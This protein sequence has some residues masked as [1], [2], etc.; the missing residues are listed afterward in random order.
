MYTTAAFFI[1][2]RWKEEEGLLY[3][4]KEKISST[5]VKVL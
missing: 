3:G 1:K 5:V 4:K 2:H